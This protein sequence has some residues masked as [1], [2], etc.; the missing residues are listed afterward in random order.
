VNS[1]GSNAL[2]PAAGRVLTLV[3]WQRDTR[4]WRWPQA[5]VSGGGVV[6]FGFVAHAVFWVLLVLGAT[7]LGLRRCAVFLVLWGVGYAGTRWFASGGFVLVSYVAVLDIVL[8]LLV[9]KRDVRLR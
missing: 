4:A 5:R 3:G 1:A 6:I 7:E 9:F 2:H 8:V